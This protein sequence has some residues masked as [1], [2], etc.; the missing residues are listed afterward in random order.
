V[1]TEERPVKLQTAV[2]VHVDNYQAVNVDEAY[3]DLVLRLYLN[4]NL[5]RYIRGTTTPF[6][7][8]RLSF[9]PYIPPLD[10]AEAYAR[11]VAVMH[12]LLQ[13]T[14]IRYISGTAQY[15]H[16]RILSWF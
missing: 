11:R 15:V 13:I 12:H 7:T 9:G 8:E 6:L 2:F 16:D 4:E 5:S 3:D 1:Q 10:C 14:K